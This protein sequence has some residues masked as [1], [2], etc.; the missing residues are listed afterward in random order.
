M[1]IQFPKILSDDEIEQIFEFDDNRNSPCTLLDIALG[2]KRIGFPEVEAQIESIGKENGLDERINQRANQI[3]QCLGITGQ[4]DFNEDGLVCQRC[5]S[6]YVV[7]R[8]FNCYLSKQ[9]KEKISYTHKRAQHRLEGTSNI[10]NQ[11]Y[12]SCLSCG[13]AFG[14]SEDINI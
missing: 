12:H 4:V 7:W 2:L 6:K 8:Q 5:G 1:G 10:W 11:S 13:F 3:F 9:P 14:I